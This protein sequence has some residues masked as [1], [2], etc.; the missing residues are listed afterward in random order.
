MKKEI[1]DV[2]TIGDQNFSLYN[3][4]YFAIKQE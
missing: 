4:N 2:K 3:K 1:N